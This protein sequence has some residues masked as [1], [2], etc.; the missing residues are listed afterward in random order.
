LYIYFFQSPRYFRL[1]EIIYGGNFPVLFKNKMDHSIDGVFTY[2]FSPSSIKFLDFM[3]V[4][5]AP[6]RQQSG[7][8]KNFTPVFYLNK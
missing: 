1:V 3:D 2:S 7:F 8:S 5:H 4:I 6:S